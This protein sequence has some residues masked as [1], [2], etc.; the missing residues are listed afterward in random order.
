MPDESPVRVLLV[1]DEEDLRTMLRIHLR[2]DGRFVVVGEAA[3]G[4]AALDFCES[5]CP[6]LVVLDVR[7][8]RLDGMATLPLLAEQCPDTRVALYTAFANGI[9]AVAVQAHNAVVF[10]KAGSLSGLADELYQFARA[11]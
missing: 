8:P 4:L 3:D 1:D 9:N 7:M 10:E 6:D 5:D 2:A 11:A